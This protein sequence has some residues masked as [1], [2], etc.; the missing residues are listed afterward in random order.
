VAQLERLLGFGVTDGV[1]CA[2]LQAFYLSGRDVLPVFG[3]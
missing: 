3:E 2:G 1:A